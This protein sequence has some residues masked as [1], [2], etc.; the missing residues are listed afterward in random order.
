MTPE[1][2]ALL[3]RLPEM[4]E[5]VSH[6]P[7]TV[8]DHGTRIAP[9]THPYEIDGAPNYGRLAIVT[10]EDDAALI[11]TAPDLARLALDL[12]AENKRLREGL[13]KL[14]RYVA[15]EAFD[16]LVRSKSGD[17]ILGWEKS[18]RLND[19]LDESL[20]LVL[21]EPKP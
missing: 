7:W 9:G 4:V 12:S 18:S 8:R 6:G 20:A 14:E 3:E 16:L 13:A 19:L 21:E 10:D 5:L 15:M 11:A 17:T 1:Q 2:R